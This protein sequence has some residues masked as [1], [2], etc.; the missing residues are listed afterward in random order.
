M[1][2]K[3]SDIMAQLPPL[4]CVKVEIFQFLSWEGLL[5]YKSSLQY[6]IYF[7][8]SEVGLGLPSKPF[9]FFTC[10]LQAF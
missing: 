8:L 1:A 2:T 5:K 6:M 7:T 9:H 4:Y 3:L 10:F